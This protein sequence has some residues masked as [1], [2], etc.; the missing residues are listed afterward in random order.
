MT[1]F[2]ALN[3][4][5]DSDSDSEIDNTQELQIEEALKIYQ[6]A[7]KAHSEGN[8]QEAECAYDE[9]FKSEIFGQAENA[10][11]DTP[12]ASTS[13]SIQSILYLAFKNHAAF[14]LDRF[15][16]KKPINVHDK[17]TRK[18][19][20]LGISWFAEALAR[21]SGD[22]S[23]WR[24]TAKLSKVFNSSRA[25]RFCLESVIQL[26][27][28]SEDFT[29]L[30]T[31][32]KSGL[33]PDELL[34]TLQLRDLLTHLEDEI[35]F[36]APFFQW[37]K[38]KKAK[39]SVEKHLDPYPWLKEPLPARRH[40]GV[41]ETA[42]FN[43][44]TDGDMHVLHVQSRTWSAIGKA[45]LKRRHTVDEKNPFHQ[46]NY[47]C[48]DLPPP[49]VDSLISSPSTA[50]PQETTS[51]SLE[52]T[53]ADD[54]DIQMAEAAPTIAEIQKDSTNRKRKSTSLGGADEHGRS[55]LSKR[56]RD[57]E[58][59]N[60]AAAVPPPLPVRESVSQDDKLFETV[61]TCFGPLG[62]SLGKSCA[63]KI[64][65][66]GEDEGL[67]P[68]D[69]YLT[70]FKNI[71]RHWDDD[72][73]NVV[74]YG[75]GI[76]DPKEEA[77]PG[78]AL[79]SIEA[80]SSSNTY[81][82]VLSGDE[83]LKKWLRAFDTEGTHVKEIC[84]EWLKALLMREWLDTQSVPTKLHNDMLAA[85]RK[86][87]WLRHS[88]PEPLTDVMV[89]MVKDCEELLWNHFKEWELD[90]KNRLAKYGVDT[91]SQKDMA[92]VE[93]AQSVF[94]IFLGDLA[95]GDKERAAL[96]TEELQ[97]KWDVLKD[98]CRRWSYLVGDL[99]HCRPRDEAGEIPEDVLTFR[100]L[101]A[102][103]VFTGLNADA[104]RDFVLNCFEDLK[105][106][107]ADAQCP[108][109]ELPNSTVM[110]EISIAKAEREISKLK[111]MDF[112]T[113]IFRA[114][115]HMPDPIEVI[116]NLEA[117]L[118]PQSVPDPGV[119]DLEE[120]KHLEEMARF[121]EGS[122][123]QF[124][125]YLW[126][127]LREAY[128]HEKVN[129]TPK[130]Y[131]PSY[132]DH[133]EDHRQFILLKAIR[134]LEVTI[135]PTL[136]LALEDRET[137]SLNTS[138]LINS[139]KSLFSLLRL[140]HTY[141]FYEDGVLNSEYASSNLHSYRL[142]VVKFREMLVK[143]WCLVYL[144]YREV[145]EPGPDSEARDFELPEEPKLLLG[146]LLRD[147]HDD[148]GVRHYCK[149]SGRDFLKLVQSEYLRIN[150]R[151][152][153]EELS[154]CL[155]CRYQINV[156]ADEWELYEH[157]TDPPE[158][159]DRK[160]AL[161]ILDFVLLM[162][163][164]KKIQQLPRAEIRDSLDELVKVIGL[165]KKQPKSLYNEGVLD[166]Y[167]SGSINPRYLFDSLKGIGSISTV[168]I[169]GDQ[170]NAAAKGLYFLM[171]HIHLSLIRD[172]VIKNRG[173][174]KGDDL[175]QALKYFKATLMCDPEN[176][177]A[178]FRFA[179]TYG[180]EVDEDLSWSAE[181][182]NN[183]K[184]ELVKK[185][186]RCILSFIMALAISAR[187]TDDSEEAN[188]KRT[189]MYY[190]FAYR[191]Y[192]STRAPMSMEAWH[193]NEFVRH[194]SGTR[195]Q[196][197]Y[198]EVA[199]KE[200]TPQIALRFAVHLLT[201]ALAHDPENWKYY[202][203]MGKCMGKLEQ[204]T[205]KNDQNDDVQ[206]YTADEVLEKYSNAADWAP[207]KAGSE[208]LLEPHHKLVSAACKYVLMESISPEAA[209]K[210]VAVSH[211]A[212]G[213]TEPTD[214]ASFLSL[215]LNILSKMKS[216]D[217]QKWHHRMTNRIASLL[218]K[219]P[220]TGDKADHADVV[221]AAK[222]LSSLFTQ[223]A[224]TLA[225]WRPENERP[226][227]HFVF[228][229]NYTKFY[230]SLLGKLQ[231]R[232][233]LEAVAKR[234]RKNASGLWRWP[235]VWEHTLH[236]YISVLRSTGSVDVDLS[237][238]TFGRVGWDEFQA[239]S[240]R[241]EAYCNPQSP[242]T[243]GP[244]PPAPQHPMLDLF[245]E[246]VE[247]RRLNMGSGKT[248]E[249]DDL[250]V[251]AYAKLYRDLLPEIMNVDQ[252]QPGL[253]ST[254]MTAAEAASSSAGN[255]NP[256]HLSNLMF[257]GADGGTTSGTA[258]GGTVTPT[259]P[260]ATAA[261]LAAAHSKIDSDLPLRGKL[262]KVTKRD[263]MSKATNL[264]KAVSATTGKGGSAA[265]E[266]KEQQE[267][268]LQA[269]AASS[270]G[271]M[272]RRGSGSLM[273]SGKDKSPIED[274]VVVQQLQADHGD[275]SIMASPPP[276]GGE[277]GAEEGDDEGAGEDGDDEAEGDGSMVDVE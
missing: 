126:E 8:W 105:K 159:L 140:L 1:S 178:W 53:N 58:N 122:S 266:L 268:Q 75:E 201:Q 158:T 220:M 195:G 90:Y 202:Y 37:L 108:P 134:L 145:I 4:I 230:V 186:R 31:E 210:Y 96:D 193:M 203:I 117:V 120:Q 149:L 35:T 84:M 94:E 17:E 174:V 181:M 164:K 29:D 243:G 277:E 142:V 104:S 236:R 6:R 77:T 38:K 20:E 10:L 110:P 182:M 188:K 270:I 129:F 30:L 183:Q 228:A 137:L 199:H 66:K 99:T 36:S 171:G 251:D 197:M 187:S 263:V 52:I 191:I 79:L 132:L 70:D 100:Y 73:G 176:W 198:K 211:Y 101:W 163:S 207:D 234:I 232:A 102:N 155:H 190:E 242:S 111:T 92:T 21:D 60:A 175:E 141:S 238:N 109:I 45:L 216:A 115:T 165:P 276:Q 275:D 9:L 3:I 225:I 205:Y 13:S 239:F 114:T 177:E 123:T 69:Q 144:I 64:E 253:E 139:L 128:E 127:R 54:G 222:E 51:D 121:L 50:T 213:T 250:L 81:H 28:D 231:D 262:T 91:F 119:G 246:V 5:P 224:S 106:A 135:P 258:T 273:A 78:T 162:A 189:S 255:A 229:Y 103:A 233:T 173:Q 208:L 179:Q 124:K 63:L 27:E 249:V 148:L 34:A 256:M 151:D 87:S 260:T 215:T 153:D 192:T 88:W 85:E 112:F 19:L 61:E 42:L 272:G 172:R 168:P 274:T 116:A 167:L 74:L 136:K 89:A 184:E 16:N 68:K 71:L 166:Q 237:D 150:S 185:E 227:R 48:L 214:R 33:R 204:Y 93:F 240:A 245:R 169:V 15:N 32:I 43:P 98:T 24:N 41:V 47:I 95:K 40:A 133:S 146:N 206:Y 244:A 248:P 170:A 152:F 254:M 143:T 72:K 67:T 14:L 25:T 200:V 113:S 218:Y 59:A 160:S 49:S 194:F 252:Q 23:L 11:D 18:S 219:D 196:G 247:L 131:G 83:G 264:F 39:K 46:S 138:V 259:N 180:Q 226:G 257:S 161:A 241:L 157:K 55:R 82:P 125:L 217:K 147:V 57:R 154:Q 44:S 223:K 22:A 269:A 80:S 107:L 209:Y 86:S 26:D 12:I 235:E 221:A 130:F 265:K 97:E 65:L 261:Q 56:V 7:I 118:D 271:A 267:K 62:I 76:Q 2:T 212:K 156:G